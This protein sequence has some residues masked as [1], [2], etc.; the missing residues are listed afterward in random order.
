MKQL[1]VF[2][3]LFTCL[4]ISAQ[5]KLPKLKPTASIKGDIEKVARDYYN[6]FL[7]ISG[8]TLLHS[9]NEIEFSSKVLPVG[10]IESRITKFIDPR[11]FIWQATMYKT[12]DFTEAVA[13][14]KL[15]YRQLNGTSLKIDV[16]SSY[17]LAGE[18]DSPDEGRGFASSYLKFNGNDDDLKQFKIEVAMNYSFP[19]WSVRIL[20]YEKEADDEIRP[21]IATKIR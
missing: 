4:S 14:Y 20:M 21:T 7:N 6:D 16:N 10:A 17:K 13:K 5:P 19:E 3:L 18:Y 15:Y 12:E 8:D 9:Q 1:T 2:V 11:T